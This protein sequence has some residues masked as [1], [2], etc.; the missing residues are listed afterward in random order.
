MSD[1]SINHEWE[2]VSSTG[3]L[4]VKMYPCCKEGYPEITY[5]LTLRRRSG[6][7]N[8][9]FVAPAAVMALLVPVM[10]ML[11][12]ESG[13]K[14]TLGETFVAWLLNFVGLVQDNDV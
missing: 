10:F 6:Y 7:L 8:Y 4:L 3:E 14:I 9:V 13:E 1:F 5:K 12:P 11:P 2:V